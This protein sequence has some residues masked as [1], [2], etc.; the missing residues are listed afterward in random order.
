MHNNI[1]VNTGCPRIFFYSY[2]KDNAHYFQK[3][4]LNSKIISIS[5]LFN[6]E[7]KIHTEKHYRFIN[8]RKTACSKKL[9]LKFPITY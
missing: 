4:F 2:R 1:L 8:F 6:K 3:L 5:S 7:I 9:T